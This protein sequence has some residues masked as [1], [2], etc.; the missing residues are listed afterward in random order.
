MIV[1]RPKAEPLRDAAV[2]VVRISALRFIGFRP[3]SGCFCIPRPADDRSTDDRRIRKRRLYG[4]VTVCV[5][6]F[7]WP[8]VSATVSV[9]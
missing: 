2:A 8:S 3:A 7:C 4:T 9:T 1:E 6:V 5:T